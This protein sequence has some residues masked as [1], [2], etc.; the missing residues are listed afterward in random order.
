MIF[1]L[2]SREAPHVDG[3]HIQKHNT[4]SHETAQIRNRHGWGG[5]GCEQVQQRCQ[6]VA[7]PEILTSTTFSTGTTQ[8]CT[9]L[10]FRLKLKES[11]PRLSVDRTLIAPRKKPLLL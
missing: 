8:Y 3:A 1:V 2:S 9:L 10:S 5:H 11:V 4:E 7:L 6:A